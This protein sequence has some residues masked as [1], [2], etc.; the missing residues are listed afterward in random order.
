M[1]VIDLGL[2]VNDCV[3][4]NDEWVDEVIFVDIIFW[5]WIVEVVG[6]YFSKG[7]FVLIEGC[8]KFDLWE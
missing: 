5:G 7:L 8:L 1:V 4:C 3:K 2:V 6:E